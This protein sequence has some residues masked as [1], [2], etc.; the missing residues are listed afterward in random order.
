VK[1]SEAT[2]EIHRW[3]AEDIFVFAEMCRKN[4]GLLDDKSYHSY[5]RSRIS[6]I[7]NA[8]HGSK[9]NVILPYVTVAA[10]GLQSGKRTFEHVN[11]RLRRAKQILD[12]VIFNPDVKFERIVAYVVDSCKVV[13]TT[14]DEN[15]KLEKRRKAHLKEGNKTIPWR[16]MYK[17]ENCILMQRDLNE[18]RKFYYVVEGVRFDSA[19]AVAEEHDITLAAVDSRALNK[20]SWFGWSKHS[21]ETDEKVYRAKYKSKIM[22]KKEKKKP[23]KYVYII[24]NLE[25]NETRDVLGKYKI[26]Y[27]ILLQRC[28]AKKKWSNWKRIEKGA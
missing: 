22:H 27:N 16:L 11:S 20:N 4:R 14:K 18:Y 26:N 12:R 21:I 8:F 6:M 3:I 24:D 19:A 28:N 17:I 7:G 9:S 1:L 5:Y 25:Y 2:K 23:Q 15:K 13:Q 10:L